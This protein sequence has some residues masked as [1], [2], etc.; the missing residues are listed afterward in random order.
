MDHRRTLVTFTG[1]FWNGFLKVPLAR[2]LPLALSLMLQ[3]CAGAGSAATSSA[4]NSSLTNRQPLYVTPTIEGLLVCDE[5]ANDLR[6]KTLQAIQQHCADKKLSAA[7]RLQGLL[8]TLEPGGPQGKVQLGYQIT[9]QLLSQYQRR[10]QQH[11]I[12]ER[13]LDSLFDLISRVNRPVVLYLAADHFDSQGS[14]VDELLKDPANLMQFANGAPAMSSYF[15]YRIVPFTLQTD[16]AIPVNRYRY[17]ALRHLAKRILALPKAVQDR[18]VGITLLGETHHLFADF[19]G[20]TGNYHA[21]QVTDYSPTAVTG[22]RRWLAQHYGNVQQFNA[23][24]GF[25]FASFEQVSPPSK[26]MA[27]SASAPL[28]EHFD[29][30]A[31]GTLPVAGWLWDPRK[32]IDRLSLYLNG[33]RVAD[34]A[35]GMNRLD[36]YRAVESLNTPNVGFRHD[37]DFS[38]LPA[39]DHLL[40]VVAQVAGQL[41]QVGRVTIKVLGRA[42]PASTARPVAAEPANLKP[43]SA[44]PDV[45]ASLDLPPPDTRLLFNPLARDWNHYRA[46]QVKA[47]FSHFHQIA[48][49][50]GLPAEKLYSHQIVPA[51]NPTWNPQLFASELVLGKNTPW[52]TGINLYGG[53]TD[54]DWT[55]NFLQRYQITDYGL[56]EFNPQQWKRPGAALQA[57]VSHY[58]AGARFISPYYFSLIPDRVRGADAHGVNAMELRPDNPRDGSSQFY[59]AIQEISK[60]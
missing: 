25:S 60:Q 48:R 56:P 23:A 30:F 20:G 18:I 37:F 24:H 31:D 45:K 49:Q 28:A 6:L 59:Q 52:K 35:R 21:I 11:V 42:S 40:Q 4:L 12:D 39:G 29:A 16:P 15:G 57:M 33:Q 5:G 2:I 54:S 8:D 55:R 1:I 36:V 19:E 50:A 47:F 38:A 32:R 9:F 34:V 58:R 3:P 14:L 26:N 10:G 13:Q 41:H 22:F 53:A 44:L 17:A 46:T 43:L 27:N 51:V 7:S